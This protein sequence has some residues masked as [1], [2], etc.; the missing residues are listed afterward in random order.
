M[1]GY[2]ASDGYVVLDKKDDL[3]VKKYKIDKVTDKTLI[4]SHVHEGDVNYDGDDEFAQN[5]LLEFE[6]I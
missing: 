2:V 6:R 4:L 1:A 5:V 3:L